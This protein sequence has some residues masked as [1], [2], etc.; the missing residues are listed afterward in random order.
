MSTGGTFYHSN[1]HNVKLFIYGAVQSRKMFSLVSQ[2]L[3]FHH[4]MERKMTK[5]SLGLIAFV[6][7]VFE[8]TDT[9]HGVIL[10]LCYII[11]LVCVGILFKLLV[12]H[13][14]AGFFAPPK[15]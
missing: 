1:T 4:Q 11:N 9:W 14:K 12:I 6:K 13:Q 15:V 10:K 8:A 2:T 3:T 7:S 5:S